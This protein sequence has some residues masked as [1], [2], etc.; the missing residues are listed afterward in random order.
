MSNKSVETSH[1]AV[2]DAL[3][4]FCVTYRLPDSVDGNDAHRISPYADFC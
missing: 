1:Q 3:P 4:L 2:P